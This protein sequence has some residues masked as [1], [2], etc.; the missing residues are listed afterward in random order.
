MMI[1]QV[2]RVLATLLITQPTKKCR[3]CQRTTTL[4]TVR[5]GKQIANVT[6]YRSDNLSCFG[7]YA[8]EFFLRGSLNLAK[9][10][11]REECAFPWSV[12]HFQFLQIV[13][14][15]NNVRIAVCGS[16]LFEFNAWKYFVLFSYRTE[17]MRRNRFFLSRIFTQ[18]ITFLNID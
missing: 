6:V 17:N 5:N 9:L 10:L 8:F 13:A 14:D 2:Q 4:H 3:L 12:H 7:C 11:V 16:R 18:R 1:S 15:R